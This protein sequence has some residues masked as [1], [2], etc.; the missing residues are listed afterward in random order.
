MPQLLHAD[1]GVPGILQTWH[2][3]PWLGSKLMTVDLAVF[4]ELCA[5]RMYVLKQSF[6]RRAC[7]LFAYGGCCGSSFIGPKPSVCRLP[8]DSSSTVSVAETKFPFRSRRGE[9]KCC[10]AVRIHL[11]QTTLAEQRRCLLSQATGRG[12]DEHMKLRNYSCQTMVNGV[13]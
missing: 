1:D 7:R 12:I 11:S 13:N 4:P 6:V 5:T 9:S 10:K 3:P 2:F 8:L